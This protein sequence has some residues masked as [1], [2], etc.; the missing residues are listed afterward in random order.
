MTLGLGHDGLRRIATDERFRMR[1]DALAAAIEGDRRNGLAPL[2]VV[3][4]VGTTA[5]T[6]V[7]P[8]PAIADVCAREGLWLHVDA[9][10]AGAAAMVPAT[11]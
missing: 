10:Y 7:D 4:T 1:P 2:A 11:A 8:V 5:V 3:A 6:S 9:A